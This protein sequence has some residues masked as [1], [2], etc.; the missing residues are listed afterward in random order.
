VLRVALHS[1]GFTLR[2]PRKTSRRGES[3]PR[4]LKRGAHLRRLHGTIERRGLPQ[5]VWNKVFS[6]RLEPCCA[7]EGAE[8]YGL[9]RGRADIILAW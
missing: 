1:G 9:R 7:G 3:L 4:A 6:S 8:R 5:A 2:R